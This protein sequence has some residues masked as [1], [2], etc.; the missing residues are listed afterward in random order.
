MQI[1]IQML[2]LKFFES[3]ST[4]TTKINDV[5]VDEGNHIY[6]AMPMYSLIEYSDNY[7]DFSD[8]SVI[9][10]DHQKYH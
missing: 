4:C 1:I 10:E 8:Y 7:S 3:F 2:R 6:V 9:F 5:F